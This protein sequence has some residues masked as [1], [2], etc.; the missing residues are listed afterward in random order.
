[1]VGGQREGTADPTITMTAAEPA[2]SKREPALLLVRGR[3]IG[4]H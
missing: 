2:A 1:M 4:L 3:L